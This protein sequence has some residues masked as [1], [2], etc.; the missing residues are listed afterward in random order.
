MQKECN[1]LNLPKYRS[2]KSCSSLDVV[3][4]KLAMEDCIQLDQGSVQ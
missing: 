3:M 2:T 1:I 4:E